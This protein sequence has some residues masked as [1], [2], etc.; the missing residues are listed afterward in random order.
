MEKELKNQSYASSAV[1]TDKPS[2]CIGMQSFRKSV[3]HQDEQLKWVILPQW[4]QK[5][6]KEKTSSLLH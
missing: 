1:N 4:V 3:L 5:R 6:R 2:Y